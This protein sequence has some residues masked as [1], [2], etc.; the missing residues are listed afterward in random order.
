M[1]RSSIVELDVR[2]ILAGG[3]DPFEKI[4]ETL[5][6]IRDTDTL[7]IINT[8]EPVPLLNVLKKQGY[9]YEV[10]RP[11]EGVVHTYLKKSGVAQ[12]QVTADTQGDTKEP[13]FDEIETRFEGHMNTIDVTQ[14]ERPLPMVEV[15]QALESLP[16]GKAL[17]V[18][19]K[20]L[21]EYLLPELEDRGFKYVVR[22][23]E[24]G[25]LKLIIYK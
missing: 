13:S 14:L 19:H 24:E 9:E 25:D 8:F 6:E 22:E 18:N 10:E 12:S 2:S 7:L 23:I 5:K 1:D 17:Y 3:V 4:M 11:E 16:A 20:R 15:L 21:P